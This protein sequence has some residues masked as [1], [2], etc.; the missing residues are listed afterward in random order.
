MYDKELVIEIIK[1][2]DW[3][4]DQISRRFQTIQSSRYERYHKS[5]LI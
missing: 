3:S 5:S 2:I 4:L 1:N